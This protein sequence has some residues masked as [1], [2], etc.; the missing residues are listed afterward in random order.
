[1]TDRSALTSPTF[2]SYEKPG[3]ENSNPGS[4]FNPEVE[5]WPFLRMR[6]KNSQKW[7]ETWP[8]SV[9]KKLRRIQNHAQIN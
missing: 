2:P 1:M 8:S 4:N 7:T 9:G 3:T 6:S 5:L